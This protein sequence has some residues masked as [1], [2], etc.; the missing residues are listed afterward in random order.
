MII[1][2]IIWVLREENDLSSFLWLSSVEDDYVATFPFY[3]EISTDLFR[4]LWNFLKLRY[5][6]IIIHTIIQVLRGWNGCA[7]FF[8]SSLVGGVGDDSDDL[9]EIPIARAFVVHITLIVNLNKT[10]RR[11]FWRRS[12]DTFQPLRKLMESGGGIVRECK[13]IWRGWEIFRSNCVMLAGT[14]I[15]LFASLVNVEST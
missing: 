11:R 1:R 7:P 5:L 13:R 9:D 10:W 14:S 6:H 3:L 2:E 8:W 15:Y 12:L 4:R